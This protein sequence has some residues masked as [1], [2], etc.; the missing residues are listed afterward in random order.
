LRQL[1]WNV[2]LQPGQE[3]RQLG[4]GTVAVVEPVAD[5]QDEGDIVTSGEDPPP[6]PDIGE[7]RQALNDTDVYVRQATGD[8]ERSLAATPDE[9]VAV[10]PKPWAVDAA[11]R[12]VATSLIARGS[13]VTMQ[14]QRD[15][16]AAYPV[17]AAREMIVGDSLDEWEALKADAET[18]DYREADFDTPQPGI[19]QTVTS[20]PEDGVP[21][22]QF[23]F[24]QSSFDDPSAFEDSDLSEPDGGSEVDVP[25]ADAASKASLRPLRAPAGLT[26][27][28]PAVLYSP[29]R[30]EVSPSF[31]RPVVPWRVFQ[32]IHRPARN[33]SENQHAL[34]KKRAYKWDSAKNGKPAGWFNVGETPSAG[35]KSDAERANGVT[36]DV[37]LQQVR[38]KY[39]KNNVRK[40]YVERRAPRLFL[41]RRVVAEFLSHYKAAMLDGAGRPVG[42]LAPWNEPQL[43][44]SSTRK[45]PI[46][47]ARY[48]AIANALCHPLGDNNDPCNQV[49]AGEYA[50]TAKDQRDSKG[51]KDEQGHRFAKKLSY[52]RV[53]HDYLFGKLKGI[54]YP[55]NSAGERRQRPHVWGLHAY[56]DANRF[57][58]HLKGSS[59]WPI[60]HRYHHLFRSTAYRPSS[61][62]QAGSWL[63]AIGV[64]YHRGCGR[65][66]S[67]SFYT[68]NCRVEEGADKGIVL[69]GMRSQRN[70]YVSLFR[71][72]SRDLST[73]GRLYA[74]ALHD[75]ANASV[76]YSG[77]PEVRG[78]GTRKED[79]GLVGS[80]ADGDRSS[81]AQKYEKRSNVARFPGARGFSKRFE[82]RLAFCAVREHSLSYGA[83]RS[84]PR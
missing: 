10:I 9:V 74:Y 43:R 44:N 36:T 16:T 61:D 54:K 5:A 66:T 8:L 14:V 81:D 7:R 12:P 40:E 15:P 47:A 28:D 73:L 27:S 24:D 52:Q 82:R 71:N 41:Y 25:E 42:T 32:M 6:V 22:D 55:R 49:V 57:Q 72:V 38:I 76:S 17:I 11:G 2:D 29:D 3:L 53:Y 78:R 69:F 68:K 31:A 67:T 33:A 4:D 45:Y 75:T 50:G 48:W 84:C 62:T 39:T 18:S 79:S 59:K 23:D 34:E 60:F 46:R 58:R 51:Y 80:D 65:D 26:E 56:D 30:R 35:V 77:P 20:G 64:F 13:T 37:A 1:S 70:T 63:T 19:D 83:P 21:D